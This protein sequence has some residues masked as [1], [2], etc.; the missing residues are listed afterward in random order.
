L[1]RITGMI[2]YEEVKMKNSNSSGKTRRLLSRA[3]EVYKEKGIRYVALAG[4]N[5][6]RRRLRISFW[7]NYYRLFKSW[8]TFTLQQK[9]YKYFYHKYNTTWRNERAAEIPII[10]N[11]VK[12]CQGN[13]L[14][15]GN[16][17]SHYFTVNHDIV[18]K[19]EKAEG[20]ITEDVTEIR[21]SK[22][23]DLIISISTLEHVGWDENP[24]NHKI[25]QE[26]E[27]TLHAIDNLKRLLNPKGKIV[28]TLPL[29]FNPYLDTFLKSGKIK[30]DKRFCLKRISKDNRWIET[31]WKNVENSK[32]N[33]PFPFANG[34]VIGIIE[35]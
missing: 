33:S 8:K 35:A 29:G 2:L 13:I 32:F 27:K 26:P 22:K 6:M 5:R 15:V 28:V 25:L 7:C 4:I 9:T 16:V 19:Y 3:K 34:L 18:D 20:V 23:Y 30:F 17:L 14:E 21:L 1:D 12:T 11:I 24:S 10:W 31:D